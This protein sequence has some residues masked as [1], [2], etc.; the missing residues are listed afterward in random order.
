[1]HVPALLA[2]VVLAP[3]LYI[4]GYLIAHAL[5]GA[6]Q[7]LDPLER[8]YE[9]IVASALLNG[10]LAFTLAEAGVFA[11]WRHL[12]VLLVVCAA[13]AAVAL[14][15]GALRLP[16]PPLGFVAHIHH[17]AH[18][19]RLVTSQRAT[20]WQLPAF[21]AVGI[22]F[23]ILVA[24]PFE[25]VLGAR[26][27]GVYANTGFAIARTGG[28]VQYDDL[29]AQIGQDQQAP[30]PALREAARQAE[31][32]FLGVQPAQRYIATR[33]R[34]AGFL[35]NAGELAR[36]RVVPQGFH[37]YP[38]WIGLL[39]G[40]LGLRGGL[41]ATGVLGLLGVWSVGM[42]GRRLAGPWIGL[43]AMILLALNGVQVWFSRYSTT[44]TTAQFLTFA[45][46][47]AFAGAFTAG[48]HPV[49]DDGRGDQDAHTTRYA[50]FSALLA[51][52]AFGQLALTRID[53]ALVVGPV[54]AYLLYTWL[55]RRWKR[56]HTVLAASLGAL[57]AHAALHI[58]LIARAYFFDTLFARLQDYA[59]PALLSMPF[60]TPELRQ[61]YLTRPCTPIGIQPCPPVAGMPP[62]QTTEW[63]SVR[64]AAEIAIAALLIVGLLALRRWSR[65]LQTLEQMVRR[66]ATALLRLAAL[67]VVALAAYG[68]LIRPQILSPATL[69]A[70]PGCLSPAQIGH[71]TGACLALQ[72][73]VGA[74]VATPTYPNRLAYLIGALPTWLRT[75]T[76]T[77]RTSPELRLDPRFAVVQGNMVRL[78]WYLSPLGVLLGV[79]GFAL[80]WRHGLNRASW[81]FLLI[82][83]LTTVVFVRNTYGTSDQHYI[84]ILRRYVA[85]VYPAFSLGIAYALVSLAAWAQPA[86]HTRSRWFG[87]RLAAYLC[88]IALVGFLVVTNRAIYRHTEYGGAL[89]Q[90]ATIA[91]RFGPRDVVLFR[92]GH[93]D[94]PDLIVTPLKYAYGI[95]AIT[96]K[97][98]DPSRYAEHLA[99]YIQRWQSQ[100]RQ[101]YLALGPNGG[102]ELPG[103]QLERSGPIALE[104]AEFQQLTDK[105]PGAAQPFAL[106]FTL[107]RL[108]PA[109]ATAAS[110]SARIAVDDYAAQVRGFYRPEPIGGTRLAWTNGDAV[111]RLPW[112]RD[113][114]PRTLTIRLASGVRPPSLGT[115]RACLSLLP[116]PSHQAHNAAS[117]FIALECFDLTTGI[118]SYRLQLDPRLL[119][120]S[121]TG[122]ALLRIQSTAWRP[123]EVDPALH[124]ERSLGVQFGGLL[125]TEDER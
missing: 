48:D 54:V 111:L 10:W 91:G 82:G 62:P 94:E 51:G 35:I 80:W 61:T 102:F 4:P 77:L 1:L 85:Q 56:T 68:Y 14:R 79:A 49:A 113:A 107:Y 74:P 65:P 27:A 63:N 95:D 5:L 69:A 87:F 81:P 110:A 41:L 37:L 47:Y 108:V 59:L 89:D 30:D 70:L 75:G 42:L 7:P 13:C 50:R 117:D 33:L 66:R 20:R 26:D 43:L 92:G 19:T 2:T 109:S 53:F 120:P 15:R 44:E 124:D 100:G 60:L 16:N 11:V 39:T 40:L 12:L 32:N 6:A 21:A 45:G 22:V 73:Y 9:R 122:T 114:A 88:G 76:L 96:I 97:S 104:L 18:P 71:P 123:A 105:K 24:R 57:L 78:G 29:V 67:A 116:E 101:V 38:A 125:I 83:L 93:R 90:L 103:L 28:I 118:S 36:G 46:L 3:L 115:A 52:V 55:A 34:A 72:G 98:S 112:P 31:T 84:Y 8:H 99:R 121:S 23:A 58:V 119:P 25:V 106:D 86:S 64:I 17:Q